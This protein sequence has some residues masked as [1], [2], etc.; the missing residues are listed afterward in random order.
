MKP[1][2]VFFR[3]LHEMSRWAADFVG[4]SARNAAGR[5]G[6]FTLVLA[7]GSTPRELYSL[8]ASPRY[9]RVMPWD[10]IHLFQGDER[11][12]PADHP[13][14]NFRVAYETLISRTPVPV[15][16]VHRMPGEIELPESAAMEYERE[17]R[18]FFPERDPD[19]VKG[20]MP[21]F[22]LIL[23]GIG[24]D[25]HTASLFPGDPA[26]E[27]TARWV[28]PVDAA[29]ASPPI[30]RITLTLPV[31]NSAEC[32]VMLASGPEKERVVRSVV[33][34]PDGA[35][36]RFPAGMIRPRGRCLVLHDYPRLAGG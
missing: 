33:T 10:R 9:A 12:V 21:A 6:I 24:P 36:P 35:A 30:P 4:E 28:A 27:E 34:D 14:S 5:K 11:L 8:L 13:H 26:V 2:P 31:I 1:E 22:D 25:G 3:D 19:S 29:G 17:L 7:G 15:E 20:E 32:V 18:R 16:N 23:L